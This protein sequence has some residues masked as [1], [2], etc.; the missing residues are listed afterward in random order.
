M[1]L[2]WKESLIALKLLLKLIAV[3]LSGNFGF[4]DLNKVANLYIAYRNIQ[5]YFYLVYSI[6]SSM[7]PFL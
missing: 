5:M 2:I 6:F 1:K 4:T 7:I 3:F